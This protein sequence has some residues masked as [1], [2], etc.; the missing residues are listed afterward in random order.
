MYTKK[1]K[2]VPHVDSQAQP[3]LQLP[4]QMKMIPITTKAVTD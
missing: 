2:G 1:K 4:D 3:E